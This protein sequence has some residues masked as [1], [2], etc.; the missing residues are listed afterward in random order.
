MVTS[1]YSTST[2]YL[3]K[4]L[5][6][7][8]DILRDVQYLHPNSRRKQLEKPMMR[9]VGEVAHCLGDRFRCVFCLENSCSVDD[10][11]DIIKTKVVFYRMET[12]PASFYL[13]IETDKEKE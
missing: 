10:L 3:L 12:I 1:F 2:E 8:K 13:L 7:D 5:P 11:K 4:N 9:L 6:L